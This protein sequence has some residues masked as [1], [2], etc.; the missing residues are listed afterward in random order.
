[1][2]VLLGYDI[3]AIRHA[4]IADYIPALL[5]QEFCLLE[6]DDAGGSGNAGSHA[7]LPYRSSINRNCAVGHS[8][9]LKA[10]RLSKAGR[11]PLWRPADLE[12]A[13]LMP[14]IYLVI[15]G[16][17]MIYAYMVVTLWI[18][19]AM[20]WEIRIDEQKDRKRIQKPR[21]CNPDPMLHHRR[22]GNRI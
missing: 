8:R 18:A 14:V 10:H 21:R 19:I 4:D 15:G 22:Q 5:Q 7:A 9:N 3:T 1:M 17:L 13:M 6:A 16:L 11:V 12:K 2:P 20:G